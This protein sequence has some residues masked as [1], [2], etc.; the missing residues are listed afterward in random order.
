[1]EPSFLERRAASRVEVNFVG[2]IV[3]IT[4]GA[5]GLATIWFADGSRVL[6]ESGFGLRQFASAFGSL[7]AAIGR[8]I[9]YNV[10]FGMMATAFEI[11]DEDV[12]Q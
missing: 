5:S 10:D 7:R 6:V 11:V 1:M 12:Q 9:G 3:D 8:T 4:G 2:K